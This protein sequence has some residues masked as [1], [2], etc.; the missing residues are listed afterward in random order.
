[1]TTKYVSAFLLLSLHLFLVG[2]L[3]LAAT[4]KQSH[5]K[6][7]SNESTATHKI[8][9]FH[10]PKTATSFATTIT[11]YANSSLPA[12]EGSQLLS[13]WQPFWSKYPKEVWFK[14]G[15]WTES[16]DHAKVTEGVYHE[17]EGRFAGLF[18]EPTNRIVSAFFDKG[19][20]DRTGNSQHGNINQYAARAEGTIAMQLA[21]QEVGEKW[22]YWPHAHHCGGKA[23]E[24][25]KQKPNIDLALHRLQKGFMFVGLVEEFDLSVCLFH[26]MFGGECL[27]L[28]FQNMRPTGYHDASKEAVLKKL[29]EFSDAVDGQLYKAAQEIFWGNVKTHNVGRSFCL[30]L[31]PQA[32]KIFGSHLALD[33]LKLGHESSYEY[34]WP[35]R[36]FLHDDE[37]NEDFKYLDRVTIDAN[38]MS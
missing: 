37:D 31:C 20:G 6:V 27:P 2:A 24:G 36:F 13:L 16:C 9:W 19:G 14:D 15:I 30:N 10:P 7:S 25:G 4:S 11:H 29:G 33:E 38:K 3:R 18:R 17:F 22:L 1:M 32:G 28:E 35:G 23:G 5:M 26:A 8:A 34:D 12:S 21:G